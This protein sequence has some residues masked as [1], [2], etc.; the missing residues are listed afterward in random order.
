MRLSKFLGCIGY[1]IFFSMAALQHTLRACKSSTIM[2]CQSQ[3]KVTGRGGGEGK[4]ALQKEKRHCKMV[5]IQVN[6]FFINYLRGLKI[7]ILWSET[8]WPS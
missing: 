3:S 4:K 1:Q 6:I 5:H 7:Q 2:T 8:G